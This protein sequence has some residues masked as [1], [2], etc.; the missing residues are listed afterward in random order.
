MGSSLSP[1]PSQLHKTVA[2]LRHSQWKEYKH[3]APVQSLLISPETGCKEQMTNSLLDSGWGVDIDAAEG[4]HQ[5]QRMYKKFCHY[6]T[7]GS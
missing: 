5:V 7:L 4:L 2:P 1:V 6:I 3:S